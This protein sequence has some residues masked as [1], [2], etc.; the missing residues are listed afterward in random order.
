MT[1][2]KM[3]DV[4]EINSQF[5]VVSCKSVYNYIIGRPFIA[6]LNV[7]GS[8]IHLKLK[9]HNRQGGPITVKTGLSG[10]KRIYRALKH[11]QKEEECKS[12]NISITS[13]IGQLR[14]MN[15]FPPTYKVGYLCQTNKSG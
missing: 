6:A 12:M 7:M 13:L 9:F 8:P 14:D 2:K 11:D 1:V 3:R 5:Q 4:R 15:I 10:A